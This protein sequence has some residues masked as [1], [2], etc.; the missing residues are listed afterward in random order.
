MNIY[1]GNYHIIWI[2]VEMQNGTREF[3]SKDTRGKVLEL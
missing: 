1:T 3:K 2:T